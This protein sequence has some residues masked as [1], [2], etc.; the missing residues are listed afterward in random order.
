MGPF[1]V[2]LACGLVWAAGGWGRH[3]LCDLCATCL[4]TLLLFLPLLLLHHRWLWSSRQCWQSER[5]SWQQHKPHYNS[6][7]RRGSAAAASCEKIAASCALVYSDAVLA[8]HCEC[9]AVILAKRMTPQQA[10][11][12]DQ[13]S[14]QCERS[15]HGTATTCGDMY[16]SCSLAAGTQQL[17]NREPTWC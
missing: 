9:S 12:C 8:S 13:L 2:V 16:I 1:A 3:V 10:G 15:Q 11:D 5:P 17:G 6:G 14:T 4:H 7:I